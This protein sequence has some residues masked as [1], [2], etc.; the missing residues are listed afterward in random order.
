M[1]ECSVKKCHNTSDDSTI[2]EMDGA[3]AELL[4]LKE[5]ED[6]YI[7]IDCF[8]KLQKNHD[9]ELNDESLFLRPI[10]ELKI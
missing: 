4:T 6:M 3:V 10:V 2:F 8:E 1:I 9:L 5:N 7:C